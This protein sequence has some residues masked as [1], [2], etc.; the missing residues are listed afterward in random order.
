MIDT[1]KPFKLSDDCNMGEDYEFTSN[2]VIYRDHNV[3]IVVL[4]E[5]LEWDE[6]KHVLINIHTGEVLSRNLEFYYAEQ[7]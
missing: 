4:P 5:L 2:D 3:C 1:H 6:D 7:L